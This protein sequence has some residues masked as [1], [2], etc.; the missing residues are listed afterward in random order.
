MLTATGWPLA[1][2]L[3]SVCNMASKTFAPRRTVTFLESTRGMSRPFRWPQ[4][5]HRLCNS[6]RG[7]I[8]TRDGPC[9]LHRD[10]SDV[11]SANGANIKG[12]FSGRLGFV[13]GVYGAEVKYAC[14]TL[15]AN[16]VCEFFYKQ[17][18]LAPRV[19]EGIRFHGS[20]GC[21]YINGNNLKQ[22]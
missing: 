19:E 7:E 16:F 14:F 22:N 8:E 4:I 11:W 21:L 13:G 18:G 5:N 3:T 10:F 12:D 2:R 15:K 1:P 6:L 20:I 17:E 9:F